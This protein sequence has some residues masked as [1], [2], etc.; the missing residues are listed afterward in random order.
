MSLDLRLSHTLDSV[1]VPRS[2]KKILKVID[3]FFFISDFLL[4]AGDFSREP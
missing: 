4:K 1:G 3:D 2:Y